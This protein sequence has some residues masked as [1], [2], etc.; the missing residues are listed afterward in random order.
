MIDYSKLKPKEQ[1]ELEDEIQL[2][3]DIGPEG[4]TEGIARYSHPA[5]PAVWCSCRIHYTPS[6]VLPCTMCH[7]RPTLT[8]SCHWRVPLKR[9]TRTQVGISYWIQCKCVQQE[10]SA[11]YIIKWPGKHGYKASEHTPLQLIGE[12]NRHLRH[13]VKHPML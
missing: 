2:R 9:S 5:I 1:E 6:Q 7:Y 11:K 4:R 12:W 10:F 13:K 8:A 3:Q